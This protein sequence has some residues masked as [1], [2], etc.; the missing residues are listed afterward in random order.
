MGD[1]DS[2]LQKYQRMKNYDAIIIG[3]GQAGT[4]LSK[5]LAGEGWKTA[6][7][8]KDLIGH[9]GRCNVAANKIV[10]HSASSLRGISE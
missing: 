3:S 9:G 1:I 4:P 2:L 10:A 5:K 8:E 6:L 7:I